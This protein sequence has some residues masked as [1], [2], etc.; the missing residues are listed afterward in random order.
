MPPENIEHLA[1]LVEAHPDY[2]VT[3][4]LIVRDA[5]SSDCPL[6]VT[7]GVIVDTETTG[8]SRSDDEIIEIAIVAFEYLPETGEVLRV[9]D[10]YSALEDPG[11]PIPPDSTAVHGI[12]DAMVAGQRIDDARVAAIL[13]GVSIVIAHN[14]E[15]DRPFLERRLPVFATLPWACSMTQIDWSAEGM[16]A[17]SLEYIAYRSGFFF[18]AHRA[19]IDCRAVLEVIRQPL[20]VS[21]VRP[22]QRLH[23]SLS[24]PDWRVYATGAAFETKDLLKARGYRW[25]A[26]QKLW[27][28]TLPEGEMRAE[29]NWLKESVY[30]R[31]KVT[32]ELESF[33]AATRFSGRTGKRR[34]AEV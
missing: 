7:R 6:A 23:E 22:L 10:T 1:A 33:D 27:H 28:T 8:K 11:R 15:F 17:R 9:T 31:A 20:P 12:T 5:Y 30:K 26:T 18:D 19:E 25:D 14:A 21:G 16:G 13:K 24:E 32:L 2:R 29:I 4:R 3:R 34:K